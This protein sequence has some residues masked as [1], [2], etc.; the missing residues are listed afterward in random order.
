MWQLYLTV[1]PERCSQTIHIL[2]CFQHCRQDE[3]RHGQKS[4]TAPTLWSLEASTP[5]GWQ[6][7]AIEYT[8]AALVELLVV[9]P[10]PEPTIALRCQVL[11][12]HTPEVGARCQIG[13]AEIC[14]G[15]V[16]QRATLPRLARHD[17]DAQ[18][19]RYDPAG[20]M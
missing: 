11:R 16:G 15:R 17:G 4:P 8:F 7:R 1:I 9:V 20:K 19:H 2:D 18:G 3:R 13:L 12:R 5:K 6:R 14:A 10:A